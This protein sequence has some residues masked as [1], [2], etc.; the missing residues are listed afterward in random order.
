MKKDLLLK[1]ALKGYTIGYA[2]NLNF[3]TY[4]M[5]KKLPG[6][7]SFMSIVV[8]VFGLVWTE[9]TTKIISV[10]VLVLGI[11]SIYIE[12]FT[13]NIESYCKRGSKNTEQLN[14]LR[15]LYSKVKQLDENS[16]FQIM[17]SEYE[18][19]EKEFNDSCEP[20]Q[21][22]FSNWYAHFKFFCEKD[23][24]WMND[25]I[26]FKLWKDKIPQTAKVYFVILI[27]TVIIYYCFAAPVLNQFFRDI[28]FID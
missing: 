27:V 9:F 5:V 12:R 1:I 13:P 17:E 3:A 6:I 26:H 2:A 23:I 16:N 22:I 19:I 14:S 15:N 25:E 4:D 20:N 7:I 24:S 10:G 18:Q 8:G 21:I 11:S 28:L